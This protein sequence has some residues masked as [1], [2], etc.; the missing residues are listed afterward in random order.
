MTV[1]H[2]RP[3]AAGTTDPGYLE[4]LD[5][6]THWGELRR[7]SL[8]I[9]TPP[10]LA[11]ILLPLLGVDGRSW[12]ITLVLAGLAGAA[13]VHLSRRLL[14]QVEPFTAD[15]DAVQRGALGEL[16][17]LTLA[18]LSVTGASIAVGLL[19]ALAGSDLLPYA[20]A[21]C[22]G[23]PAMLSALP[24]HRNIETVRRRLESAGVRTGLWEEL[25]AP[26]PCPTKPR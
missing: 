18:R 1:P 16:R 5:T 6:A 7:L 24:T 8:Q 10:V 2:I 4:S 26:I 11:F 19:L 14:D 25:L 13:G 15:L 17:R 12:P 22:V 21:F 20:I 23:W 3:S 9:A